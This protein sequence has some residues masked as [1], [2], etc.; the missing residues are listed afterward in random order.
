MASCTWSMRNS[1]F[2]ILSGALR[3]SAKSK[4]VQGE[5]MFLSRPRLV[6]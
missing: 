6:W 2:L 5:E 4:D 3:K 1:I